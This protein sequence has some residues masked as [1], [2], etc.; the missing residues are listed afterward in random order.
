MPI[1]GALGL[2]AALGATPYRQEWFFPAMMIVIGAYYLPFRPLSG[3]WEF[4]PLGL[5]MWCVGLVVAV[6]LP[7]LAAPAGALTGVAVLVVGTG[8]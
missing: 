3:L 1:V 5:G 2:P 7:S 6:R 8:A 4:V